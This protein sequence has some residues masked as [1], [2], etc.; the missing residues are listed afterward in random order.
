M[1]P[2]VDSGMT[3]KKNEK[4]TIYRSNVLAGSFG[5]SATMLT[6]KADKAKLALNNVAKFKQFIVLLPKNK[7]VLINPNQSEKAG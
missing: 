6:S 5:A 7:Q 1:T 4:H 2:L 3:L